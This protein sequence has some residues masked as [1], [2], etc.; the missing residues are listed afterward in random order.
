MSL[1]KT[2][3]TFFLFDQL[4]TFICSKTSEN[5]ANH[6]SQDWCWNM[7]SRY[8]RYH[9]TPLYPVIYFSKHFQYHLAK[10]VSF[11]N[12]LP[13]LLTVATRGLLCLALQLLQ[14][15][16]TCTTSPCG[17]SYSKLSKDLDDECEPATLRLIH[18]WGEVMGKLSEQHN[19]S[20]GLSECIKYILTS[21]WRCYVVH[22]ICP[23]KDFFQEKLERFCFI[24]LT[25]WGDKVMTSE[26]I[27]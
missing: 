18:D 25:L 23:F 3:H 8:L 17:T 2:H 4:I 6:Q 20:K 15:N 24:K 16:A 22:L 14:M 19:I 12:Y 9:G 27:S 1:Y 5:L 26:W 13:W 21:L 11:H 7:I 10:I